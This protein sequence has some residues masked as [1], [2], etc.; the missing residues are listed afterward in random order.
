MNNHINYYNTKGRFQKNNQQQLNKI[1]LLRKE[2]VNA[3]KEAK[4]ANQ[5][6]LEIKAQLENKKELHADTKKELKEADEECKKLKKIN[7]ELKEKN[8][9]HEEENKKLE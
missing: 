8:K 3:R 4:E 2:L 6:Y 1:N 5:K 9:E 7:K